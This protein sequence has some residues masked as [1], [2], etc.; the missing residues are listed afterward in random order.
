M[1]LSQPFCPAFILSMAPTA[2]M[3]ILSARIK[4][5]SPPSLPPRS[6]AP[7]TSFFGVKFFSVKWIKQDSTIFNGSYQEK[8]SVMV[9]SYLPAGDSALEKRFEEALEHSCWS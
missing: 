9:D 7:L 8:E 2:A 4:S 6:T 1:L 3:L 5:T